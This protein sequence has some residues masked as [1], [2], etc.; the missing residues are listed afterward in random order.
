M[1]RGKPGI[2]K[3][4][5]IPGRGIGPGVL[6]D[7]GAIT[8]KIVSLYNKN[9]Y[10]VMLDP[11][12]GSSGWDYYDDNEIVVLLA[13]ASPTPAAVA[14]AAAAAAGIGS[15][16]IAKGDWVKAI[17]KNTITTTTDGVRGQLAT[18]DYGLVHKVG[19]Y[20][21][22][23]KTK[24]GTK[25]KYEN[26]KNTLIVKVPTPSPVPFSGGKRKTFKKRTNN[27][28]TRRASF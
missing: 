6:G 23:V 7:K 17:D 28:K 4:D 24:E 13:P 8:G 19:T 27:A 20:S 15:T 5:D 12:K 16:P 10:K 21:T 26:Y 2:G 1:V 18:G 9:V 11:T 14:G 22:L 25:Y 3:R